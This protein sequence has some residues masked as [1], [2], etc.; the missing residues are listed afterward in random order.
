MI[1]KLKQRLYSKRHRQTAAW[2]AS[3][4]RYRQSAKY[5][6]VNWRA[7]IRKHGLSVEQFERLLSDQ[8]GGC[9]LCGGRNADRRL[10]ID[11]DHE[12]GR[13]RGLLCSRCNTALGLLRDSVDLL[14]RA[15]AYLRRVA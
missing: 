3:V 2:R 10:A 8:G 9:A 11:H 13:I 12:T 6:A 7:K 4:A 5:R 1:D 14:T 15:V